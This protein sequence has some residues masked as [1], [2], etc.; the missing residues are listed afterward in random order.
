[1]QTQSPADERARDLNALEYFT[2]RE[3]VLEAFDRYLHAE[4]GEPLRIFV[5]CG[6]PGSGKT[7]I[8]RQLTEKLHDTWP[9]VSH[10]QVNLANVGADTEAYREVLLRMRCHLQNLQTEAVEFPH[11]DFHWAMLAAREGQEPPAFVRVDRPLYD[12]FQFVQGVVQASPD[13]LEAFIEEATTKS[14]ALKRSVRR[15]GGTKAI[16]A[17]RERALND[18]ETL[19]AELIRDFVQNLLENLPE[20]EGKACRAMLFLD[21]YEMLWPGGEPGATPQMRQIDWWVREL[22]AYCLASGI[23]LVIAGREPLKWA[24]DEPEWGAGEFEDSL[25][26][27]H[28]LEGFVQPDAQK[29]L[30]Q[31]GIGPGPEQPES[32]LQQAIITCCNTGSE[33]AP[34]CHPL[35]LALCAETVLRSREARGG[36]PRPAAFKISREKADHKLTEILLN[37][38]HNRRL[39]ECLTRLSLT[40]RFDE[41]AALALATHLSPGDAMLWETLQHLCFVEP[42]PDGFYRLH[43]SLRDVLHARVG[44]REAAADHAWFAS[45]W[46]ERDEA[47][48]AWFHRWAAH[49]ETALE[50]WAAQLDALLQ[51]SQVFAARALLAQW[52]EAALDEADRHLI[53]DAA[54]ARTHEAL[55]D[56]H[57]RTPSAPPGINLI[58]AI[59]HYLCA[60]QVYTPEAVPTEWARLHRNLGQLCLELPLGSRQENL[61]QATAYF[62]S[63]LNA[64]THVPFDPKQGSSTRLRQMVHVH[65]QARSPQEWAETLYTLG[66]VYRELPTGDVEKDLPQAI[67]CFN[68][69]LQ[70]YTETRHPREWAA[71]QQSMGRAFYERAQGQSPQDLRQAIQCLRAA[72]RVYSETDSSI[73]WAR[74]QYDLGNSFLELRGDKRRDVLRQAVAAYQA[75]LRIYTPA[76][77]PA[78]RAATLFNLGQAFAEMGSEANDIR[79]F[80][81]ARDCFIAASS[82]FAAT[83]AAEEVAKAND[84]VAQIDHWLAGQHR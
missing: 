35:A 3:D 28:W 31:C 72:L 58:L 53:G 42:Q 16:C 26:D 30:A 22:A 4:E 78:E 36:D 69:A 44:K 79:A 71:I 7:A 38:L 2:G 48:L 32:P 84:L 24:E 33:E 23:V 57:R 61:Q 65:T 62:R 43:Q 8:L 74:T 39:E 20:S 52:C 21:N 51:E 18:D 15:V 19:P 63:A 81:A 1:M 27:Q 64:Y 66:Q 68:T 6:P 60:A 40:P 47:A 80:R 73:E 12:L 41:T 76:A 82:G 50:P 67:A 49:P 54:W 11:F 29:Y 9:P 14:R 46:A 70:V 83:G 13:D 5:V 75:A 17:L 37:A 25:L 34:R 10:A 59:G 77:F 55:G 45:H 56:A